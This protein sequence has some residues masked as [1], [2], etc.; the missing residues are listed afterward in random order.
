MKASPDVLPLPYPPA[1][2][3]RESFV[4]HREAFVSGSDNP[5]DYL[6]RCLGQIARIEPQ[7]HAFTHLDAD[8]ARRAADESVLRYR[9]GAPLSALDGMPVGIKDIIETRDMPTQMG[10]PIYAGFQP[11][12][13]AACVV[14][15]KQAGAVIVGKTVTTEFATGRAGPTCNPFD[16]RRTPGG[17]SS[18]SAAAVGAGLLP[19]ALGTQT[20]ASIIRPASYCGVFGWKPTHGGLS[21]D[22]V[23]PLS[24]TLDHLGVLAQHIDDAWAVAT[25]IALASGAMGALGAMGAMGAPGAL[26][27]LG[28]PVPAAGTALPEPRPPRRLAILQ[29]AGWP[30]ADAES[31][32]AFANALDGLHAK[33]VE[34]LDASDGRVAS[35]ERLVLEAVEVAWHIFAW[36]SRWPLRAYFDC[37][38]HLVGERMRELLDAA[39]RTNA[40]EHAQRLAWREGFRSSVLALSREVDGF[41]SLA[42]AGPAILGLTQTGSRLFASAWTLLGGPSFSLP[43]LQS[44]GLPLGLQ[45]MGAPGSDVKMIGIARW[46]MQPT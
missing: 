24:A 17:S 2:A 44:A 27:T 45:L 13:N 46:L 6:E 18:G 43:L 38:E 11:R 41:V 23:Q 5:R 15:L 14:A 1:H 33:G 3:Q 26:G 32:A 9:A 31:I 40:A 12:R 22:G 7:L 8:S 35:L 42:S 16:P 21:L 25:V 10:S 29:T 28:E 19:A 4:R 39:S 34:V 36:E 20:L 30:E 37:G